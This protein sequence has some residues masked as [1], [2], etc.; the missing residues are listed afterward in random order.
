MAT[1]MQASFAGGE[2][3]PALAAR[4]DY[5]KYHIGAKRLRNFFVQASGGVAN[6]SGTRFVGRVRDSAH[7]VRLIPFQFSTTQTYVLEF[8][9]LYVRVVMN[10]G[11]VLEP[12]FAI[13]A[14]TQASPCTVTAGGHNFANGDE[15]YLT[16]IGGM[17]QLNGNRYLVAGVAGAT[18]QLNTLDGAAVDATHFAAFASGGTAARVYTLATPYAGSDLALLKFTQSADVMTL[19]HTAY[20]PMDLTRSQ[21]WAWTLSAITFQPKIGA[22]T[23]AT[24]T[25]HGGGGQYY[26]YQ[27][28][29]LTDSPA[30]EGLPSAACDCQNAALNQNT[31]VINTISWAAVSGAARY[32]VYKAPVGTT[33][34]IP[35][36]SIYGYIGTTTGTSFDDANIA[37]DASQTP[38]EGRNP[39]A[40]GNNPGCVTYYQQ[41]KIFAGSSANPESVWMT[42]PGNFWNM[43]TSSPTRD[44]DS[45]TITIASQQVNAVKHLV[46]VSAL[47]VLTGSGAFK[48]SGGA[49]GAVLTPAQ[50]VVQPQSYNGCSDVPPL[51]I[52]Y[53]ILYVQSKGSIVRDLS[54]NFYVDLYT[55]A[56]ITLT[57][58]HLFFGHQIVAWAWA[59]EPYKLVWAVRDD[60]TALTLTYLKTEQVCG[61]AQHDTQGRFKSVATISEGQENAVYFVVSRTAPG[62]AGGQS[63][64]Y[65]E[66]LASRNLLVDGIAD[67][68]KGW[69]VDCGLQYSGTPTTT[70]SGLDHLEGLAVAILAD[71]NVEP[72]Q[73]V[74][75]GKVTV[76]HPASTITVGLPYSCDLQTLAIDAGDHSILSERK[77]VSAV[78][79]LVENSRGLK[80][81]P[82][83]D[84]LVEVKERVAQGYG[85]AVPL[86]TGSERVVIP[87]S[88]NAEG[89]VLV[90]QDNPLPCSVLGV[91][92]ELS[93]GN[94]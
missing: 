55:G 51:I 75:G 53:D 44:D 2:L 22:P 92:P 88:W 28:T 34:P 42:Q 33:G 54:Y 79:L 77:R 8:G 66:R 69:F 41:R 32:H 47:L 6:R 7:P 91:L 52:D 1:I 3:A 81:G 74:S 61:W 20:A 9:H 11:H 73:V 35:A 86:K 39:F 13:T 85:Q 78:T 94:G 46:S 26:S 93:A 45:I 19:T 60:G 67:V 70:V 17:T 43:D 10:G 36:G 76:Q 83:A 65:V 63:V 29:A 12:P 62:V 84:H 40:G 38:P 72:S 64:Q 23:G 87:P 16:G 21:H 56:D 24:A 89:S 90:R 59:E 68:T 37:S 15:V 48:I 80:I 49:Q 50:T 30:E 58:S 5:S 82:D 4:V 18:F 57:A 71:G 31:G 25:P 14:A 27:V